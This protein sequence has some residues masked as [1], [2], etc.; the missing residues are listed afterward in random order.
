MEPNESQSKLIQGLATELDPAYQAELRLDFGGDG[1]VLIPVVCQDQDSKEVIVLAFQ[2]REAF[3]ETQR[4]GYICFW[5]RSRKT[6]WKK[7]ES[8]GNRLK[9]FQTRINCEQNSLLYLV[10]QEGDG[11]CHALKAD[12]KAQ[13]GCY[14][15]EI[16]PQGLQV[17]KKPPYNNI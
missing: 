13:H 15:R 1:K 9:V 5:S 14:Y 8:S 7:G 4:S 12:G 2:N 6:L 3:L 17:I 11:A 16:S 10:F